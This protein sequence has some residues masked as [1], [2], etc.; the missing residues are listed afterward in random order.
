MAGDPT[1]RARLTLTGQAQLN[2]LVG[3]LRHLD[4]HVDPAAHHAAPL[5]LGARVGNDLALAVA[6]IAQRH[7]HELTEDRLLD[8][9]DLATAIAARA[10]GWLGAGLHAAA[11]ALLAGGVLGQANLFAGAE[12]RLFQRQV[13]VVAQV[14]AALNPL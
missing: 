6:A 14:L 9:T 5:A 8:A 13:Q 1:A 3:A 4:H 2:A 10:A 7:V 12:D 11:R